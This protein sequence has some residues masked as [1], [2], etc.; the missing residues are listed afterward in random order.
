MYS[1]DEDSFLLKDCILNLLKGNS[2]LKNKKI[3]DM[4]AGSGIQGITC[5]NSKANIKNVFFAD[6]DPEVINNLKSLKLK[7]IKSN[8]FSNIKKIKFDFI[9]F[10]PPYLPESKYDNKKDTTAGKKGNEIILRFLKEAK[11]HIKKKGIILLLISS[12]SKPKKIKREAEH[13]GYSI[14]KIASKRMFFEI[15]EVYSLTR[16]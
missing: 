11:E 7:A 6:I 10:N 5:I 4:G 15:L 14:K 1:P 2:K 3:L 9:F 12:L 8:L 16:K 13:L